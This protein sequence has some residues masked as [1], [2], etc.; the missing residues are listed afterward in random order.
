MSEK[1]K[2]NKLLIDNINFLMKLSNEDAVDLSIELDDDPSTIRKY[3][4][5]TRSMNGDVIKKIAIHYRVTEDLLL[6][7]NISNFYK[8]AQDTLDR[9][10]IFTIFRIPYF[11]D[12]IKDDSLKYPYSLVNK[13]LKTFLTDNP[14]ADSFE[15]GINEFE[16][17]YKKTG[18]EDAIIWWVWCYILSEQLNSFYIDEDDNEKDVSKKMTV[19]FLDNGLNHTFIDESDTKDFYEYCEKLKHTKWSD[20]VYYY[21]AIRFVYGYGNCDFD[22]ELNKKIG[23]AMITELVHLGNEYAIQFMLFSLQFVDKKLISDYE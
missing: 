18:N 21:L 23:T 12:E 17:I 15:K 3:L 11:E 2:I 13:F 6:Y 8:S 14:D 19:H 4:K 20:L 16:K 10:D 1:R 5:G 9:T 22:I 7:A